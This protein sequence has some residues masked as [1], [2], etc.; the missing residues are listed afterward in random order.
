MYLFMKEWPEE[1]YPPWA[2][3]PGY[4]V[5]HDIAN[6]IS[7]RHQ[8]GQ[9]KVSASLRAMIPFG[10]YLYYRRVILSLFWVIST[11]A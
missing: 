4:V 2:H 10:F 7:K 11:K 9:L 5:S 8:S 6:S 3:G 1:T